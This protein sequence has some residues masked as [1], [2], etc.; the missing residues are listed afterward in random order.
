MRGAEAWRR[1]DLSVKRPWW[2]SP[3]GR[4]IAYE[5]GMFPEVKTPYSGA[6]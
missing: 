4:G 2:L 6:R 3:A 5:R 1:L